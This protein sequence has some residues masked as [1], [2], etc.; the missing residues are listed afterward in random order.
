MRSVRTTFHVLEAVAD[1]QPIGL[2]ELARRLELPKTT[3][4]RSLAV[5]SDLEL[6]EG[7]GGDSNRW[8]MGTRLHTLAA[9]PTAESTLREAALTEL[10]QLHA[11]TLET[12]HLTHAEG[13]GMR[14]IERI[15]SAHP[16]RLVQP[17]GTLSP[18]YAS[19]NGKSALAFMSEPEIEAY[20]ARDL[21][22]LAK[23]TMTDPSA[24]R[25]DLKVIRKRGYAIANEELIDGIT[26]VAASIRRDGRPIGA[27]SISGPSGRVRPEV[28]EAYGR[29]VVESARKVSALLSS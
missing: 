29:K 4:Q 25:A 16:L 14:L 8:V 17:I 26:S 1:W 6:I 11:D 24:I 9:R 5:L 28:Y 7:D 20:L 27:M 10:G 23:N 13:E 12:I 21:V 2:S 3:V 15:D 18:L 19:S 22:P